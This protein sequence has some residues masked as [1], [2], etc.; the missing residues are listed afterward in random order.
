MEGLGA[1]EEERLGKEAEEEVAEG[2]VG[3]E[4]EEV[5][6]EEPEDCDIGSIGSSRLKPHISHIVAETLFST[7]HLGHFHGI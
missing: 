2:A 5:E 7:V 1:V 6:E 4:E 3:A